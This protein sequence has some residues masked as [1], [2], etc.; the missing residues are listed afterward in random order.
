MLYIINCW[1]KPD[2]AATVEATRTA[3]LHYLHATDK[4]LVLAGGMLTEDGKGRL[5]SVYLLNMPNRKA[6]ED[7][8]AAEP[9]HKAGIFKSHTLEKMRKGH[10]H[11]ENAPKT[12]DGE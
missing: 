2:M 11:P 12:V 3:H 7:W 6:A 1:E 10:F 5:G 8:L 4:N 9:F